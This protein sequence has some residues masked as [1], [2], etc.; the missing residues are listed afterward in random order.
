MKFKDMKTPG[1]MH[2]LFTDHDAWMLIDYVA[3]VQLLSMLTIA[4]LDSVY[5]NSKAFAEFLKKQNFQEVLNKIGLVQREKHRIVP[6][7]RVPILLIV[8][9][10]PFP[11]ADM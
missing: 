8:P 7:V 1:T 10:K 4:G 3:D 6:H 9:L 11:N 2:S 5:D